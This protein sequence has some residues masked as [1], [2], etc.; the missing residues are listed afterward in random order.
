MNMMMNYNNLQ[1]AQP[2][3]QGMNQVNYYNQPNVSRVVPN[4]DNILFVADLP[5]EVSE[6]DLSNFFKSYNFVFAKIIQ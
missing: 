4:V 1:G 2:G 6:E 3:V 5:D